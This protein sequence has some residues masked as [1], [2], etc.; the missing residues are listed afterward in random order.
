MAATMRTSDLVNDDTAGS[1][2]CGR[3]ERLC[4]ESCALPFSRDSESAERSELRSLR[5]AAKLS[6]I[7]CPVTTPEFAIM[8]LSRLLLA[9]ALLAL[10]VRS[11]VADDTED[12]LK[13]ENWEG[14]SDIWKI[15]KNTIV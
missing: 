8:T 5:V 15:E 14:R 9:A 11:A 4:Y 2:T 1:E 6:T 13:P 12:F 10:P 7:S 3:R